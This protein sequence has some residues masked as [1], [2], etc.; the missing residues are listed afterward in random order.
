MTEQPEHEVHTE[1]VNDKLNLAASIPDTVICWIVG[2]AR[3]EP[4]FL[5]VKK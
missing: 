3:A 2:R 5:V 1:A 4:G